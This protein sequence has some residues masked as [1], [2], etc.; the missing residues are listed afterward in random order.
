MRAWTG[1][2]SQVVDGREAQ[3]DVV[4][5]EAPVV[6]KSLGAS[7]FTNGMYEVGVDVQPGMYKAEGSVGRLCYWEFQDRD[8]TVV[9]HDAGEGPQIM[10]I[11]PHVFLV[12]SSGGCQTWVR[13]GD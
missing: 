10:V 9:G 12:R 7:S 5:A 1:V 3:P 4:P 2:G 11:P 8:G 6:P 13:A